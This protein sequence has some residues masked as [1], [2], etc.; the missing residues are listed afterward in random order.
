MYKTLIIGNIGAD[1][2]VKEIGERQVVNFSVAVQ[3]RKDVTQWVECSY[4]RNIDQSVKVAEFITKGKKIYVE[5]Q[6]SA[7]VW[8]NKP[9]L[10]MNVTS[11]E[12]IGN[13]ERDN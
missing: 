7:D 12:L 3:I 2:T 5:G 6:C 11:I 8:E 10:K 1:A 4:W 13:N 9:K